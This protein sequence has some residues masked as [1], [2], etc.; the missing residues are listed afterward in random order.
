[1]QTSATLQPKDSRRSLRVLVI[2]RISTDHQSLENID[3]SYRYVEDYL[4]RQYQGAMEIRH[5]GERA[6]G[7]LVDR[8]TIR[9]AEDLIASGAW[10]LVIAEDLSRIFRNPRHQ[11][12]FVQD[13]VDAETRV[14]CIADNLDTADENWEI[15]LGAAALRHG[16]TI[17]DVRRRVRRTATHAFHNGG[18]V[19]RVKY[20]Y[21]KLSAEEAAAGLYGRSG[22]RIARRPECTP[23]I[24]EMADR[25]LRG[26]HYQ[27]IAEWLREER[28]ESPP[29]AARWTAKLVKSLLGDP[30]LSGTRTFR[31][32][33][34]RPVYRTGKHRRIRNDEPESEHYPELAHLSREQYAQVLDAIRNRERSYKRPSGAAHPR[35]H[36]PRSRSI[37]PGQHARC[38][39]CRGPM[40]VI[41]RHVKCRNAC[42]KGDRTCWNKVQM[43]CDVAQRRI[44]EW[45]LGTLGSEAGFRETL[46]DEA[47]AEF[48][49]LSGRADDS[50]RAIET[51]IASLE[52]Q[53]ENL[54]QA[55]AN[56]GRLQPLVDR[57]KSVNEELERVRAHRETA[58]RKAASKRSTVSR[59]DIDQ[60]L[61][62]LL[63]S[64]AGASFEFADL[65]RALFAQFDVQPVQALDRPAVYPVGKLTLNGDAAATRCVEASKPSDVVL[66]LFNPPLHIRHLASCLELRD[67]QPEKS[68]EE[69]G[70]MLS[71]SGMTVRRAFAYSRH[72]QQE[73]VSVAYRELTER[74]PGASRWR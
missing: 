66:D 20:G 17:P 37:W 71:V 18:M 54:S 41:G 35:F 58:D 28:V 48:K 63:I 15:M 56:G 5:L 69:I 11:Y 10:D 64:V 13:A 47:V 12:N 39:I 73:G 31:K 45:I 16:T 72:M 49:R 40:H 53:A 21:R 46:V 4:K 52:R 44:V 30:I 26:E 38:A 22:L 14:I 36:C 34:H 68:P 27:A 65:M 70:R 7:M 51:E 43:R 6:S 74:P 59:A 33:I 29:Y 25:V 50:V 23:V 61:E 62:T 19:L 57:L 67:Q 1:M 42:G 32:V 2:G 8:A 55:I 9:E 3:A 60:R 24:K